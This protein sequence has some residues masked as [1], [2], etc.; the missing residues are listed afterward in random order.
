MSC[1]VSSLCIV[2]C[3]VQMIH[4]YTIVL[5]L[6]NQVCCGCGSFLPVAIILVVHRLPNLR[7][8]K[9]KS[10]RDVLSSKQCTFYR[11][12]T[13]NYRAFALFDSSEDGYFSNHWFN[14]KWNQQ[15][16]WVISPSRG[17]KTHLKTPP[18]LHP[19]PVLSKPLVLKKATLSS[20]FVIS[21]DNNFASLTHLL[22]D[23]LIAGIDLLNVHESIV[24]NL[25]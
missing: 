21:F 9:P 18:S 23:S 19:A 1:Y 12:I 24:A 4:L 16:N 22:F 11:Q 17:N 5:A 3:P 14:P 8:T 10:L 13:Q 20:S 7:T 2:V 6:W 25:H 15:S